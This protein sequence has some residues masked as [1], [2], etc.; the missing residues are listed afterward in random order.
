MNRIRVMIVDGSEL[1]RRSLAEV[2]ARFGGLRVTALA[3]DTEQARDM[4]RRQR[5]DV[6]LLDIA[7]PQHDALLFLR[8][9]MLSRPIPT[10]VLSEFAS[11]T[12]LNAITALEAGA[13]DIIYKPALATRTFFDAAAERIHEAIVGAAAAHIAKPAPGSKQA[14]PRIVGDERTRSLRPRRANASTE[15]P[16]ERL[17]VIGASTGGSEAIRVFLSRCDSTTP[18]IVV[19]QHM[20][21][22]FTASLAQR[23]DQLCAVQ[24]REA[25]H[26]E[27]L[28]CG[29]ALIAPGDRHVVVR[30]AGDRHYVDVVETP[31][32]NRHRPSVDVLFQSAARSCGRHAV[33]V[34]LTGMGDDG[35]RGLK[36]MRD[37]GAATFAQDEAS[38][39]VYGMPREAVRLGAA[40]QVLPL[41]ALTN[42]ALTAARS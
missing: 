11:S 28:L 36:A 24:V 40:G 6:I 37:A 31:P 15:R 33:G 7:L 3:A 42:A 18:A 5:P 25:E 16:S 14:P 30:C 10:V 41:R 34:I 4:L 9:T 27:L 17:I 19:V 22:G 32:V 38:C 29:H 26:G 1:V 13:L 12:S 23:L 35:A 8:E 39:V 2:L 21:P 20:P